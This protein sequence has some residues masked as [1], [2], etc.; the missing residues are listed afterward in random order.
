MDLSTH[1]LLIEKLEASLSVMTKQTEERT[2]VTLRLADLYADRSRLKLI[3][4]E[5]EKCSK[6]D[7]GTS[8]RKR[9]LELYRDVK[10]SL[11]GNQK[12]EVLL[13]MAHLYSNLG[14]SQSAISELKDIS[15]SREKISGEFRARSD[16]ALGEIYFRQAQYKLAENHLRSALREPELSNRG[17]ITY[18]L[19]WS[20]LNQGRTEQATATLE[21]ILNQ[22]ELLTIDR[23]DGVTFHDSF[24]N[25]VAR[26]L[27]V[28]IA[29][30]DVDSKQ[31]EKLLSLT[32][33]DLRKEN[34]HALAQELER[35]G[36]KYSAALAWSAY[37][38]EGDG[39]PLESLET[40]VR[41]AQLQWDMGRKE[42][43]LSEYSK[44]AEFIIRLN[45]FSNSKC[46]DSGTRFRNFVITWH[47]S[48]KSR[49][50]SQLLEAYEIYLK[51]QPNDVELQFQTAEVASF[52]KRHQQASKHYA[53]AA[54][55]AHEDASSNKK[56]AELLEA[57][58]MRQIESAE[59]SKNLDQKLLAY[60][61]YLRLNPNGS[62]NFEIRYQKA[63]VLYSKAEHEKA[64][65]LFKE[66]AFA[67]TG[68]R[69]WQL[70][71]ADLT[72]DTLVVLKQDQ[73]LLDTSA[74]LAQKFPERK[75]DFHKIQ[76]KAALELA[77]RTLKSKS[78]SDSELR[79][80]LQI[81]KSVPLQSATTSE[82]ILNLQNQ[83]AI[84]EKLRDLNT[85]RVASDQLLNEK[86]LSA[87]DRES[88]LSLKVWLAELKMDFA[89]ALNL[90]KKM[91]LAKLSSTDKQL[92]WALLAELA[93]QNPIPYYENA[94][95]LSKSRKQ[96]IQI[97]SS[98]VRLS[99]NPW[100]ELARHQN[101]LRSSPDQ[102]AHL[103]LEAHYQSRNFK[104]V[105]SHLSKSPL[106]RTSLAQLW[107]FNKFLDRFKAEAKTVSR[108]WLRPQS[109]ALLQKSIRRRMDLLSR[110][111]T[112]A[113]EAVRAK[114]WAG[115]ILALA[116]IAQEQRRMYN[117][118][119]ALPTP[120]Q[121][122][123]K[124]RQEYSDLLKIKAQPFLNTA[125]EALRK[126]DEFWSNRKALQEFQMAYSQASPEV[127][128]IL[129]SQVQTLASLASGSDR[130]SLQ[131]LAQDRSKRPVQREVFEARQ[132]LVKN[133]FN[134]TALEE[135]KELEQRRG[136]DSMVAFLDARLTQLKSEDR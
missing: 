48:E 27:V 114:N 123:G 112:L 25:D 88:V 60:E 40:Q 20:Q 131:N 134:R 41:I 106:N 108:H 126:K 64:L 8:D 50:S 21:S 122:K 6:C 76:R 4:L 115:Q 117:D 58:L 118:L 22:P 90:S 116:T 46:S 83:V 82:R 71:A 49:P 132:R 127:Q 5:G 36:K 52:L 94:L 84:A 3:A 111:D 57:S 10:R 69:S 128:N 93:G 103:V 96:R 16:A 53:L 35:I 119:M 113:I 78:P 124:Q 15:S 81:L 85:L 77:V 45:C 107:N 37:Y 70:K 65:T 68:P 26:D 121:L 30:S 31:I 79:E 61:N 120:R 63:F 89:S 24:H 97:R 102:M 17:F 42:D 136:E 133:P 11:S 80:K 51:A 1:N 13:Q 67:K 73:Q 34:L 39:T 104:K 12:A 105:E 130:R 2:P 101:E 99:R 125:E 43:A 33:V 72:L 95:K 7:D 29:R 135:L 91:K 62:K 14:Q 38:G 92:R 110:L 75:R 23:P 86:G 66:L 47:K 19:A 129:I 74:Q 32:P 44:A 18:R 54:T 59:S 9:A 87:K 56:L 28:F 100:R 98:L 55:L 109:D